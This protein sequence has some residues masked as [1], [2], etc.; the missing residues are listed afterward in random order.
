[1][2]E[3]LTAGLIQSKMAALEGAS[4]FFSG[5]L[6]T[7]I[8]DMKVKLLGVDR[9]EAERTNAVAPQIVERM[10]QGICELMQAEVGLATTGYA[11]AD[12]NLQ[13]D[14]PYAFIGAFVNHAGTTICCAEKVTGEGLDRAAMLE[15]VADSAVALLATTIQY[16]FPG[17]A[18]GNIS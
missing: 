5:G 9:A 11:V 10:A 15:H 8:I 3:S 6:T 4:G 1:M 14:T 7:Y 17:Y 16:T 12:A 18:A 13:V 2:A